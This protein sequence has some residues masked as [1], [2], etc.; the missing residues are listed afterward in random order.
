VS[1]RVRLLA[2]L[3]AL[4]AGVGAAVVVILLLRSTVGL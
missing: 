3:A 2:S 4:A 1:V